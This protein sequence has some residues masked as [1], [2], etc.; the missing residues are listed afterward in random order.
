MVSKTWF[1]KG[2]VCPTSVTSMTSNEIKLT[3]GNTN[4]RVTHVLLAVV[5]DRPTNNF[6]RIVGVVYVFHWKTTCLFTKT[7]CTGG[8]MMPKRHDCL[9]IQTDDIR[10][11][12]LHSIQRLA[13]KF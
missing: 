11:H 6:S 4:H 2:S 12:L 9:H 8:Y 1:L 5:N 10:K 7:V 13:L 3:E